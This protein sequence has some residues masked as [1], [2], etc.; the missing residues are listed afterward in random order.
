MERAKQLCQPDK[1]D[2]AA[3]LLL[4]PKKLLRQGRSPNITRS[5]SLSEGPTI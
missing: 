3:F 5:K 1:V 4:A 2:V